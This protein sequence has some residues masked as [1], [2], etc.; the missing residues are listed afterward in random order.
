[1]ANQK[2]LFPLQAMGPEQIGDDPLGVPDDVRKL[3]E[4]TVNVLEGRVEIATF[5][6]AYQKKIKDYYKYNGTRYSSQY[7]LVA[8]RTRSTLE[9][10]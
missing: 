10:I 9:I 7:G 4:D 2:Q 5:D 3:R 1:M 8:K 6:K